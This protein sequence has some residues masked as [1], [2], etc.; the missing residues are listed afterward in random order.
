MKPNIFSI[1]QEFT[2]QYNYSYHNKANIEFTI[3]EGAGTVT[4]NAEYATGPLALL[5]HGLIDDRAGRQEKSITSKAYSIPFI[6]YICLGNNWTYHVFTHKNT[7]AFIESIPEPGFIFDSYCITDID[8]IKCKEIKDS[9][10]EYIVT[11]DNIF[12]EVRFKE[13]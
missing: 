7:T 13:R 12:I 4:I 8:G 10:F 5:E 1:L 3:R 9:K 6:G 11:K 2:P